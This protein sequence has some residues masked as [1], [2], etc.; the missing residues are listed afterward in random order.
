M[1]K[2][3]ATIKNHQGI[4]CRPSAVIIKAAEAFTAEIRVTTNPD[5]ECGE[6]LTILGLMGMGLECGQQVTIQTDGPDE[7][8][9]CT[10]LVKLFE[11]EFDYPAKET[12]SA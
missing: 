12:D 11:C 10:E 9:A 2:Q 3:Q 4:H 1:I 8:A 7:E 5:Q 6:K